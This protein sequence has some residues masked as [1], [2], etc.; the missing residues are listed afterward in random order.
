MARTETVARPIALV[1]MS[2]VPCHAPVA[3][4]IGQCQIIQFRKATVLARGDVIHVKSE[5]KELRGKMT[6]LATIGR[7]LPYLSN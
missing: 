1:P 4:Q 3:T 5:R 7:S 6:I 2:S